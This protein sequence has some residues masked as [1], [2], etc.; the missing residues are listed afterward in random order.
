MKSRDRVR[1][2][3]NFE[4]TDRPPVSATFVPEIEK[5][6]RAANGID[7]PDL[8]A[9]LGNDMVKTCVGLEMSF[10]GQPEPEYVCPWGIRWR[11]V[12]NEHG[13]YTEMVEH[14]LAGDKA[15][16]DTYQIPDPEEDSQYDTFREMKKLYGDEKWMVGSSQIS[17]FEACWYLRGLEQFYMDMA[18]EQDYCCALMDKVMR[19]PLVAARK[20]AELGADMVW[21]GDD[22]SSQ[23]GMSISMDMWRR[24]LKPRY[25]EL[26]AAPKKINPDIKVAYHSCG[27]CEAILDDMIEI[28]LDVLNPLQPLAI[29]PFKIKK[30]YGNRLAL[31]GGLCVQQTMPNGTVE[32]IKSSVKRLKDECGKGGGFILSP[33]HHIQADTSLENIM[34]FYEAALENIQ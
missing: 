5:R 28:G 34:A 2:A 9:A 25:A 7:E 31:F 19:F 24:Y 13:V 3:L 21:F 33:A 26:F 30:R 27:N 20:H 15:R 23:Q 22:V 12:R 1:A 18:L 4:E 29:D 11:Y 10:Y 8:G 32:E 16:L 6:I 17:I 14:P